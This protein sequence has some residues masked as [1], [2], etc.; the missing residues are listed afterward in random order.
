[1]KSDSLPTTRGVKPKGAAFLH[2]EADIARRNPGAI[3]AFYASFLAFVPVI[4]IVFGFAGFTM[5]MVAL[6]RGRSMPGQPGKTHAYIALVVS[7]V[8][9]LG[10]LFGTA[11]VISLLNTPDVGSPHG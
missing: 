10:Q 8:V 1:M 2:D 9:L 11:Y 7:V 5:A 3:K 4:G 6:M